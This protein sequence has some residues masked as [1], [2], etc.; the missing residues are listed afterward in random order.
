MVTREE[1]M[2]RPHL[3]RSVKILT[4]L[5]MDVVREVKTWK[6]EMKEILRN[7]KIKKSC[8]SQCVCENQQKA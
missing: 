8:D 6:T 2:D 5:N 3:I 1:T 4:F 7:T